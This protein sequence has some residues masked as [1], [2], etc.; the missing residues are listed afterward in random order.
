MQ[1]VKCWSHVS[2]VGI[3]YTLLLLTVYYLCIVTLQITWT[4]LYPTHIDFVPPVYSL[5]IVMYISYV[6]I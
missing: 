1:C 3:V 6:T 2:Q 5:V 4:N